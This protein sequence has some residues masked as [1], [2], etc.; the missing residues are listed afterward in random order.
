MT[1]EI[2]PRLGNLPA[3][4]NSFVG[5]ERDLGDLRLLLRTIRAL[6]LCGPGG[7][8]KT[9]LAIR[10]GWEL[11]DEF[12]DGVWLVEFADNADP[13]LTAR[14]VATVLGI[15]DEPDRPV[16][17]TLVDALRNRQ[18]LLILDTCEHIV[19]AIADL[20]RDLVAACPLLR[21]VATSREP[22]RVRGETVWRVP[23]LSVP[24]QSGP[25]GLLTTRSLP[26]R[27][28]ALSA[29]DET[30]HE[31]VRLFVDRAAAVRPGFALTGENLAQVVQICRT[32]DGV[33]LAIELAAARV[34]ALSVEQIASRLTDRFRLLA[35]GDRT[36]PP[37]QRTLQAAVDWSFDLLTSDEQVLLRRLAVFAGWNLEMSE[38]VCADE[39][40][41]KARVLDLLATLIDKSLVALEDELGGDAR[42][43]LLDTIR[44]YAAERLA[45]SGEYDV[46]RQRHV[47]YMLGLAEE[48]VSQAF[49]GTAPPWAEQVAMYNGVA[50]EQANYRAALGYC[51]DVRDAEKGLR[52]C[53]ALRAPWIVRGDVAEG[54]QWFARFL[55][56]DEWAPAIVRARA[57]ML[58]AELAFEHQDY[59]AAAQTAQAAVAMCTA[60]AAACPAGGLRILALISLRAGRGDEAMALADAA[61]V[62]AI[63]HDDVWEEGLGRAARA[64]I[65]VRNGDLATAQSAFEMALERLTGNNGWGVAHARYGLGNLARAR[66]DDAAAVRHFRSALELFGQIG[67]STEM[68]RC[69]AGIGAVALGSLDLPTAAAS[70]GESL[71]LSMATGQRL[72]IAR[73]LEALSA[74]AMARGEDD[75]ALTLDGASAALRDVVGEPRPPA[76]QQRLDV[77]LAPARSRLGPRWAGLV[78]EGRQLS[79]HE[80]VRYALASLESAAAPASAPSAA[81]TPGR[82]DQ[83]E[84][85]SVLTAREMQIAHLIA[86]GLSNRAIAEELVISPATAARHVANIMAKLGLNSR[87]QVAAWITQHRSAY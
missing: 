54:L 12:P 25:A 45:A 72:G 34:R 85:P 55:A 42:Y 73:G 66:G 28:F 24:A 84:L 80:A 83:R 48:V 68:A 76:R 77:M 20:V 50:A 35:S 67:A 4:P 8:G 61:I 58:G 69:L 29:G 38:Q 31:A 11:A 79:A 46:F 78:A 51:L 10:L 65:L 87:A 5:R 63:Q 30:E 49:L 60:C 16:A 19:D 47:R 52:L 3:E 56:L 70:L 74:L 53:S 6:T 81:A 17:A 33:P 44:D 18:L 21:L 22:L 15:G 26:A 32:L 14:Q 27:S 23:P 41:P 9:R 37:R 71:E 57:L 13:A 2:L 62:A 36:A 59:P 7:I 82:T 64:A 43:R 40:I 39:R 1:A 75:T 86:R